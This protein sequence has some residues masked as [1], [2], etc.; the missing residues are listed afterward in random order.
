MA[1][2][3]RTLAVSE[4]RHSIAFNQNIAMTTG[5][6][7]VLCYIPYNCQLHAVKIGSFNVE[8]NVSFLFTVNR[9]V[10]GVG[11]TTFVAGSTFSPSDYGTSGV[12]ATGATF[13]T[14]GASVF[15]LMANDVIGY[16]I[17]GGVTA[18]I[19]NSSGCFIVKPIQDIKQFLGLQL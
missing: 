16:V 2:H 3:N 12:F 13:P 5:E 4:Q 14:T 1:V 11:I 17:G 7:G 8:S 19:M 18:G 10:V 6:T 9:F 15:N